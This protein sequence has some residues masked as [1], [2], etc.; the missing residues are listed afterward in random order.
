MFREPII[1]EFENAGEANAY[2]ENKEYSFCEV[3]SGLRNKFVFVRRD[4]K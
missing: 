1:L 3:L 2:M 4:K